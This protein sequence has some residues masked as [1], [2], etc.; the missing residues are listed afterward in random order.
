MDRNLTRSDRKNVRALRK[1]L[2]RKE[3]PKYWSSVTN[4]SAA[5]H[6]YTNLKRTKDNS[7]N[8]AKLLTSLT[9]RPYFNYLLA[10]LRLK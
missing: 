3:L 8:V 4:T 9:R 7:T 1:A 6:V 10:V 2:W 5:G